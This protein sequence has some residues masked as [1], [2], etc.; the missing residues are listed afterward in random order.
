[1]KVAE[2]GRRAAGTATSITRSPYSNQ[3]HDLEQSV[4]TYTRTRSHAF[5]ARRCHAS[6]SIHLFSVGTARFVARHDHLDLYIF[7]SEGA[8]RYIKTMFIICAQTF[9]TLSMLRTC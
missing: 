6:I 5:C 4:A 2:M 9:L 7:G 3:R 8:L 1:M